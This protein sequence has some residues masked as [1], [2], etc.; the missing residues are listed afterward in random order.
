MAMRKADKVTEGAITEIEFYPGYLFLIDYLNKG[1]SGIYRK[2]HRHR[3]HEMV[4][5][6]EGEGSHTIDFIDY[7]LIAGR[8]YLITP[9]QIHQ[10][11]RNRM[12]GYVIQFTDSLLEKTY[13]EV[14]LQ[15]A[16]LFRTDGS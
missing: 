5:I 15:G 13:R 2:P 12:K 9:G 4:W 11:K 8:I 14:V 16:H 6:E 3:F 7:P 1:V 10:W